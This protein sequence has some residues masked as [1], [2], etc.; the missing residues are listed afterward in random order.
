MTR[1][2]AGRA[3]GSSVTDAI[4]EAALAELAAG[5]P[6]GL[7]V[8]RVAE[9]AEVN[10]TTVYRRY[11]H[12]DDLVAACLE[13][14]LTQASELTA[15]GS[16]RDDLSRLAAFVARFVESEAGR[17]LFRAALSEGDGGAIAGLARRKMSEQLASAGAVV[18]AGPAVAAEGPPARGSAVFLLVGAVLHR[19]FLERAPADSAWQESV[20]DLLL[21]GLAGGGDPVA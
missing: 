2:D 15:T 7:S 14:V 1:R 16:L 11:P 13:R 20:V 19:V 5:G 4:L 9:R 10:K 18:A 8:E 3:R 12:R 21:R 6:D 17:A